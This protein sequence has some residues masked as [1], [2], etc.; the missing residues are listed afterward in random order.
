M[1]W[2]RGLGRVAGGGLLVALVVPALAPWASAVLDRGPRGSA[3]LSPLPAA[4][5]AFD[6][7]V[8]Q[9]AR[10]SAAV[11]GVVAAGSIVL[12]VGLGV[13]AGRGR[14]WGR[15][16][17]SGLALAPLAA[18][19][20]LIAPGVEVLMG[21]GR[22]WDWLA[23]RSALGYSCE[24]LARWA[25]LA[26]VGLA[27]GVPLVILATSS[28]LARLD[29][30][31]AEAA[32]AVGAS[33]ARIWRDVTWPI[34]RPEVARAAAAVFALALVEPAGPQAL[35]LR[36]T[37]AVQILDAARRLDDPTRAATLAVLAILIAAVGRSLIARWAGPTGP[38]PRPEPHPA[39]DYQPPTGRRAAWATVPILAAWALFAV[40]PAVVTLSRAFEGAGALSAGGWAV[41]T[42]GWLA[43]P[44]ARGWAANAAT[45]SG[46]AVGVDLA[47]LA[48]FAG[49]GPRG[50]GRSFGLAL[51]VL[52]AV[53]PLALGVGA[54][55]IPW[56]L[57]ALAGEA[58]ADAGVA[59]WLRALALEL[60]PGRSPGLLLVVAL[61]AG[62]LPMLAA[63]AELAR[64]RARP[65][66]EEAALVLGLPARR[67][68]RAGDGRWLGIVPGRPVVLA[69][70]LAA[71]N[72][73]PALVLTPYSERR[74]LAPAAFLLDLEAGG[75]DPRAAGPLAAILAANLL[76]FVIAARGRPGRVGDWFR[77]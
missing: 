74:T 39:H 53:P 14:F 71:T 21:G 44:E 58:G 73:A 76:G 2:L 28:A 42:L 22:S 29:P 67:A 46:L 70:V 52:G 55:A 23:A 26:W 37:L 54:L 9:C 18:G 13:L 63:A 6:P 69:L 38:G 56:L 45:T 47:V 33:R 12:G 77:G 64:S 72:L 36:R 35:G 1:G 50:P 10:N 75:I 3:R 17:L 15:P 57:V 24:D 61:A 68:R 40:G 30:A 51:R 8:W 32:R 34:I 49:W 5:A 48:A 65:V 59:R 4:L 41:A 27:T 19:S 31:W 25:A 60:S 62:R 7:F 43:D 66:L 11:A 16:I 20:L